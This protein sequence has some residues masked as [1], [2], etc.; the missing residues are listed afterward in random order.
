MAVEPVGR[1]RDRAGTTDVTDVVR[2]HLRD[3]PDFPE[4]GVVFKDFTPLLSDPTAMGA[5]VR[6]VAD[7]WRG[8]AEVV[9]GIEARGFILGAAV[10]YELGVGFVPVR[11]AGKLPGPTHRTEYDLEYGSAAIEVH[12]DAFAAGERVLVLDDVLATGGTA[13]ATCALLERTGA[14]VAGFEA[15]IELGFLHGRDRLHGRRLHTMLV[16]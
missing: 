15:V 16:V 13:A 5:V 7:R 14:V 1:S 6:D 3:I 11:K 8:N 2:R 9:A 12:T 4:P 10:A